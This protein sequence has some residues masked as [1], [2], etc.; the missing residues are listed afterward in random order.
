MR[1]RTACEARNQRRRPPALAAL[2]PQ[3]GTAAHAWGATGR[4][5]ALGLVPGSCQRAVD[6]LRAPAAVLRR[7]SPALRAPAGGPPVRF[8]APLAHDA[9]PQ[10]RAQT[11]RIGP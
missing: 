4:R 1:G 8:P 11:P 3:G 6:A 7:C 2:A 5:A 9:K 10:T